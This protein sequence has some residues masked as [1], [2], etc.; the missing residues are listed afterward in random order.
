MVTVITI[1]GD[2]P[3]QA[4]DRQG[5][6]NEKTPCSISTVVATPRAG[7]SPVLPSLTAPKS[8]ATSAR[9]A[10]DA[11]SSFDATSE[12]HC[13]MHMAY[14]TEYIHCYIFRSS[15]AAAGRP[16]RAEPAVTVRMAIVGS[17]WLGVV[18]FAVLGL[19]GDLSSSSG[20]PSGASAAGVAAASGGAAPALAL[21]KW[22]AGAPRSTEYAVTVNG[23]VVDVLQHQG[24]SWFSMAGEFAD[25]PVTVRVVPLQHGHAVQVPIASAVVRP[26][27]H[28]VPS[29]MVE[30]DSAVV[31]TLAA[32]AK[33]SVEIELNVSSWL[34]QQSA[35][36]CAEGTAHPDGRVA[37]PGAHRAG[38][39]AQECARAGCCF[40][41]GPSPDPHHNPWCFTGSDAPP[42]AER[43]P[44]LIFAEPEQQNPPAPGAPGVVYFGPGIHDPNPNVSTPW[45]PLSAARPTLY[46]APG[47]YLRTG[48]ACTGDSDVDFQVIGR[49]VISG[50]LL[51][52]APGAWGQCLV[53]MAMHGHGRVSISG[54]LVV[55]AP[56]MQM[57]LGGG[58]VARPHEVRG[59]KLITPQSS[60][61]DGIH[62]GPAQ[63][64]D[65][66][67]I[68]A[69]DDA[70]D[71][72][73]GAYSSLITNT[74]I[75]NTWGSAILISWNAQH[76][77]GNAV[78]DGLDVIRWQGDLFNTNESIILI[79]HGCTGNLSNF[80]FANIRVERT[81]I[82][83]RLVGWS[84]APTSWS[85]DV[86]GCACGSNASDANL[87]SV[88]G[89]TLRDVTM[90]G[91]SVGL[92]G[93]S[94]F[95][96][97]FSPLRQISDVR[98]E[99]L[100]INGQV[101]TSAADMNLDVGPFVSN[102][103]FA[104]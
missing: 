46:L 7:P 20:P 96:S 78:V 79:R 43:P 18:G 55:A 10:G 15:G 4:R 66:C 104:H 31:I 40:T 47:A 74:T 62:A 2:M 82:N 51:P 72:G 85:C 49:G 53:H 13:H 86:H 3:R 52:R 1:T 38:V 44:L 65:D 33:L 97:G 25:H 21:T 6:L 77:T 69:H 61:S 34:Q 28:R 45:C 73:Q 93:G 16:S 64:I 100:N 8:V 57:C 27:R 90:D 60:N 71:V 80:T 91:P 29:Q 58:V 48:L 101:A 76:D 12:V 70:L 11:C 23:M 63:I 14:G 39:T 102:L 26:L 22:P 37:C 68:V 89:I 54:V 30:N 35:P 56:M 83:S 94:N 17:R 98:F 67:F 50:E 41:P 42:P 24:F 103:T 59:V 92:H 95:I 87:G 84:I 88:R 9:R 5:K 99:R 81:G 36:T 32:P 19:L 75:W